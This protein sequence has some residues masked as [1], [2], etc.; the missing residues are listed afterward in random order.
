MKIGKR[1]H[2]TSGQALVETALMLPL[3]LTVVLNAVNFAFFFLVALN[4][5]SS[6]R[7]S[8]IYS[9]M[10]NATPAA[11]A[12]PLGGATAG[13][14]DCSSAA[15]SYVSYLACQDL[16][17]SVYTP[18]NSNTGVSV[19]SS[20][21]GVTGGGSATAATSCTSYG[22]GAGFPTTA[23]SDPEAPTF[24]LAR[25]DVAYKFSPPIPLTPFNAL[26][27]VSSNCTSSGGTVT[28]IFYRHILMRE[29]Q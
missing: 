29:M 6:S 8:G 25:V 26:L 28:C 21:V 4:I 9:I 24:L 16:T 13:T 27:L 1:G 20:T 17:G 11:S 23:D 19:C 14:L 2:G 15:A 7:T 3:L 5:T 12:L 22:A 10:G 18:S